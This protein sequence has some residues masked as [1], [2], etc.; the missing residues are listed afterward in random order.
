[1]FLLCF[2]TLQ[3]FSN[4]FYP[5]CYTVVEKGLKGSI[6][7]NP[8]CRDINVISSLITSKQV[9]QFSQAKKLI[10]AYNL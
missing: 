4:L 6:P 8:I 3:P 2:I 10:P 5:T 7:F 1:M 9:I